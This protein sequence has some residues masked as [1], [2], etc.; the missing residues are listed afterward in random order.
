[1]VASWITRNITNYTALSYGQDKPERGQISVLTQFHVGFDFHVHRVCS[2]RPATRGGAAGK[3]SQIV[4]LTVWLDR[5]VRH[6]FLVLLV[7]GVS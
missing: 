3:K 6:L 7:R 2:M 5:V 4:P 1:M